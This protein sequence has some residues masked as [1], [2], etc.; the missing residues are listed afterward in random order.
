MSKLANRSPRGTSHRIAYGISSGPSPSDSA[1]AAGAGT[2]SVTGCGAGAG[3]GGAGADGPAVGSAGANSRSSWPTSRSE[4]EPTPTRSPSDSG[5]VETGRPLTKVP[6]WLPRSTMW[7]DPWTMR[8]S[9]WWREMSRSRSTMSLSGARPM[10]TVRSGRGPAS[11][12]V[13]SR[14]APSAGCPSRIR[15]GP[16][17]SIRSARRPS[18]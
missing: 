3:G 13:Q 18:A 11:P 8:S 6:A 1:V 7:Q 14:S 10:R 5:A 12:A 9:A 4:T 2:F 16:V 15:L 17:I